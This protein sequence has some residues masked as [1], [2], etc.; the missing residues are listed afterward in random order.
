VQSLNWKGF[1]STAKVILDLRS[2][3][4]LLVVD[5]MLADFQSKCDRQKIA[6]RIFEREK[7]HS[8]YVGHGVAVPHA[9]CGQLSCHACKHAKLI[10]GRSVQG[11]PFSVGDNMET[12]RLFVL[13]VVPSGREHEYLRSLGKVMRGLHAPDAMDRIM[14]A[15]TEDEFRKAFESD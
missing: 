7:Q 15:V 10:F 11:V 9:S 1:L 8:T 6:V 5:E 12:V 14:S 4:F 3:D 2:K 13:F